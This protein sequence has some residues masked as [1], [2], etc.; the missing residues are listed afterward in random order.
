MSGDSDH[1]EVVDTSDRLTRDELRELKSL[2]Q[3]SRTAKWLIATGMALV[4]LFGMDKLA[5]WLG[6]K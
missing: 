1:L 2:A 4:G 6:H 5:A 3:M